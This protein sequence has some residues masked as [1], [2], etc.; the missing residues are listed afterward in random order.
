MV[1][2]LQSACNRLAAV[3]S[4]RVELPWITT[5]ACLLATL[6]LNPK[7]IGRG[8]PNLRCL[9]IDGIDRA[10]EDLIRTMFNAIGQHLPP[11]GIIELCNWDW[12]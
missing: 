7:P 1:T 9:H 12:G 5:A 2:W 10:H 8:Y 3:T 6:T 4:V 11:P